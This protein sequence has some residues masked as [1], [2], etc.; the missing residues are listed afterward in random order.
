MNIYNINENNQKYCNRNMN[1]NK[2]VVRL[3]ES[4]LKQMIAEAVQEVL[5]EQYTQGIN[6][7]KYSNNLYQVLI[8]NESKCFVD[9][10]GNFYDNNMQPCRVN[11]LLKLSD[12][13]AGE[14]AQ[15]LNQTI[16]NMSHWDMF[17]GGTVPRNVR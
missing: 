17:R 14:L 5:N 7:R 1:T 3:T 4:K 15:Q 12:S 11:G 9:I 6:V 13:D 10:K 8:G 16:G 2:R